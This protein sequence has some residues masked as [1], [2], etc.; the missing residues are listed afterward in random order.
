VSTSPQLTGPSDLARRTPIDMDLPGEASP[1][2]LETLFAQ[3]NRRLFSRGVAMAMVLLIIFGGLLGWMNLH[4]IFG[5]GAGTAAALRSD[6]NPNLLKG[7]GS[8]RVN[9]LLMGRGGPSHDG[10]DLTDTMM[11]ASIDPINHKAVLLSL[12]RDLWVNVPN[13]GV[14]KLNAV[15][16]TG[17]F[18]YLGEQKPGSTDPKAIQAGFNLVDQ[19]V[20]NVLGLN[21]DY[22][23]IVNFQAFQQSVDTVGGVTVDVPSALVD[24]TMAWENSNNPLLAKKGVQHFNG[25]QALLY[26]RSRETSSDFARGQRQRAV[27]VALKSKIVTLGTLS[28]PEKISKLLSSLGDNVQTDLT[29]NNAQRLY[30]ITRRITGANTTSLDLD[31]GSHPYVT[32]GN[33]DGQSIVLPKAGLF[34]YAAIHQF[35]SLQLKDPF[36]LEEHAKVLILNGTLIPDLAVRKAKELKVYGYNVTQTG[37]TP[38]SDWTK[39]TLIDLSGNKYKYTKHYLER[40]FKQTAASSMPDPTIQTNGADFVIIVGSDE[41]PT[42]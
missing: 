10:P 40:R 7:E 6:P 30:Q 18:Q 27:L 15:W 8:G 39:T 17:E 38:S 1:S 22:N 35:V 36:I 34:N 9:V 41:I 13:A 21:V 16:E 12:P 25:S 32:T 37:N 33:V 14:M 28:N 31:S 11:V 24:P 42:T 23:V 2:R 19:A 4:K 26:V 20:G 5:G 3:K 29:F